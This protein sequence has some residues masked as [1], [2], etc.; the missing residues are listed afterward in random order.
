MVTAF[1]VSSVWQS[2]CMEESE[3]C[4]LN[5]LCSSPSLH[6]VMGWLEAQCLYTILFP[7]HTQSPTLPPSVQSHCELYTWS[8]SFCPDSYLCGHMDGDRQRRGVQCC[9]WLAITEMPR[10]FTVSV[11]LWLYIRICLSPFA[12]T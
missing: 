9:L 3:L 1:C 2:V 8:V 11:Q 4:C 5:D 7:A 6:R 12:F 10:A